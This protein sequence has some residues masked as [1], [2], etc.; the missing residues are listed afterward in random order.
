MPGQLKSGYKSLEQSQ[1]DDSNKRLSG[2]FI[3]YLR[4]GDDGD[5]AR[6]RIISEHEE[7]KASDVGTFM[8]H[9]MFHRHEATSQRTGKVYFTTS[10]CGKEEDDDGYLHGECSLC[11]AEIRRVRQFLLWVYVY[12]VYHRTQNSDVDNPW[13]LAKLGEMKVYKESMDRFMVW[14]D[15]WH[16]T[17]SLKSKI[18]RFGS[19]TDR[20][21]ERERTGARGSRQVTYM[22]TSLDPEPINPEILEL[23]KELPDLEDIA[24]SKVRTM[25]GSPDNSSESATPAKAYREVVI[26]KPTET[27][28]DTDLPF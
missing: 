24:T 5:I 8:I 26:S 3:Q 1:E 22:L 23:A 11:D 7:D 6:F 17:Q 2:D 18:E 16:A 10:L 15:G 19:L 20:L 27:E 12:D 14:Q 28:D 25:G 21:Y 13:E 9:G 4:L